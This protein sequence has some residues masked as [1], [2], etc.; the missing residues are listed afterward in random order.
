MRTIEWVRSAVVRPNEP[1]RHAIPGHPEMVFARNDPPC[2]DGGGMDGRGGEPA[3]PHAVGRR[4]ADVGHV[5]RRVRVLVGIAGVGGAVV[6]IV[7]LAV[8][9]GWVFGVPVLTRMTPTGTTVKFSTAVCLVG[10]GCATTLPHSELSASVHTRRLAVVVAVLAALLALVGLVEDLVGLTTS[11]DNPFALDPGDAHTLAAGRMAPMTAA[12]LVALA[13]ALVLTARHVDKTAHV[14]RLAVVAVA[15]P[16]MVSYE[17]G[18][19]TP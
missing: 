10:V 15:S 13:V 8:I 17:Y 9:A 18:V 7:G 14:V 19:H 16:A 1:G 12:S 5:E 4:R 2:L 3:L 6:S 11:L